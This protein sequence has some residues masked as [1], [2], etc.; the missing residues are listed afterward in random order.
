GDLMPDLSTT[1]ELDVRP[2][3]KP[4][5]HPTIF[6]AYAALPVGGSFVLVNDHDPR[7]L[8][9][10]FEAEHPGSF[11]WEYLAREARQWRIRITILATTSL[12]RIL[13]NTTGAATMEPEVDGAAWKLTVRERDLDANLIALRPNG[14]IERHAGPNLYFVIHVVAESDD[15][16][17]ESGLL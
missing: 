2:L 8:H 4:D 10:E 5:K 7:H 15:Y 13:L 11:G 16:L 9:A 6:A 17:T 14:R 3:A 1:Q 12:P